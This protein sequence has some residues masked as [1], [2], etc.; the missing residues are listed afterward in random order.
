MG[1]EPTTTS[2]PSKKASSTPSP[3]HTIIRRSGRKAGERARMASGFEPQPQ[4]N[5][6]L[7]SS[8][9]T[10]RFHHPP[11]NQ[12]AGKSWAV[13]RLEGRQGNR[14]KDLFGL[15][16]LPTELPPRLMAQQVG[17]EPTTYSVRWKSSLHHL[18]ACQT[19]HDPVCDRPVGPDPPRRRNAW[20]GSG[21]SG[22]RRNRERGEPQTYQKRRTR[23]LSPRTMTVCLKP[24]TLSTNPTEKVAFR[25][26]RKTPGSLRGFSWAS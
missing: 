5:P 7:S 26:K 21:S 15:S 13:K 9:V 19:L 25:G 11:T 14:R 1:I 17:L 16:F 10:N 3:T 18:P 24:P 8:E 6:R 4:A 22:N 23:S 20:T 2:L 12:G